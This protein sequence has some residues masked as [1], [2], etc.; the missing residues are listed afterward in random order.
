MG[1]YSTATYRGPLRVTHIMAGIL[2]F[3]R[4]AR[5]TEH[6]DLAF[7]EV[8]IALEPTHA[9]GMSRFTHLHSSAR[10]DATGP[11]NAVMGLTNEGVP[12]AVPTGV[13]AGAAGNS[14]MPFGPKAAQKRIRIALSRVEHGGIDCPKW[15][16]R[17]LWPLQGGPGRGPIRVRASLDGCHGE[18]S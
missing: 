11:P 14:I 18:A 9:V 6:L 15:R 7:D 1:K 5:L 12:V 10:A 4:N 8:P 13:T 2:P 17:L 16:G 3:P